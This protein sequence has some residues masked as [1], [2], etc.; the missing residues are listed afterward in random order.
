MVSAEPNAPKKA[1]SATAKK[2]RTPSK[3]SPK[4]TVRPTMTAAQPTKAK[5]MAHPTYLAMI[6]EAIR[7]LKKHNGASLS[8]IR[9]YIM[10]QF[11]VGVSS[12]TV[13]MNTSI[14]LAIKRGLESG[15]FVQVKGVG[16]NGSFRLG[17]AA[18]KEAKKAAK[19]EAK[20]EE[21]KVA[22]EAVQPKS[23]KAP[24]A[25]KVTEG[26]KGK[27]VAKMVLAEKEKKSATKAP[28][29][30]KTATATKTKTA[31]TKSPKSPAKTKKTAAT[32]MPKAP[33]VKSAKA[34]PM[35]KV[36]AKA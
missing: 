35:K 3:A 30:K 21:A 12:S 16:A 22:P 7:N 2:P 26:P 25:K 20:K 19:K 6:T 33:K 24:A 4:K 23:K 15:Q 10:K 9:L 18:K 31:A 13:A 36:A 32:K 34:S 11:D 17:D 8:A 27:A 1:S 14:R 28:A 29:K 5:K